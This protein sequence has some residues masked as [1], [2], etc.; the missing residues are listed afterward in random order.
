MHYEIRLFDQCGA[1]GV[2]SRLCPKLHRSLFRGALHVDRGGVDR[3]RVRGMPRR[4]AVGAASQP[5]ELGRGGG[6]LFRVHRGPDIRLRAPR[7]RNRVR[8]ESGQAREAEAVRDRAG[9]AGAQDVRA[10]TQSQSERR[11]AAPRWRSHP[12]GPGGPQSLDDPRRHRPEFRR[13][14]HVAACA[15]GGGRGR[16]AA[17][18]FC[19]AERRPAAS[20]PGSAQTARLP[21]QARGAG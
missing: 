4:F 21:R 18:T 13:L 5:Q 20:R 9:Q 1:D 14:R 17:V 8:R 3:R 6:S 2:P 12:G 7:P 16:V 11:Q 15:L 19:E 10:G